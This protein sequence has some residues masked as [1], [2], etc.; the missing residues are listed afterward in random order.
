MSASSR[1]G[2][3]VC[4]STSAATMHV[5]AA[6][7]LVGQAAV[8]V[9]LDEPVEAVAD[10]VVLDDV[11]ADDLVAE[12]AHELAEAAVGAADVEHGARRS[13]GEPPSS[14]AV[15]RVGDEL[16]LVG[17]LGDRQ[18]AAPKPDLAQPVAQRRRR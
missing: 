12:A 1:S 16:E 18:L 2:A 9:G 11:D 7:D 15:R 3:T 10:A 14:T 4:S 17:P 13:L 5:E 6:A 8:E